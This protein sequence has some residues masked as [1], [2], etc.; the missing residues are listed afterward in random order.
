M[1][2]RCGWRV[3]A[4]AGT[5]TAEFNLKPEGS[6]TVVTWSMYGPNQFIGKVMGLFMD[7]EK[8][9]GDE[10]NKGLAKLKNVVEKK[11]PQGQAQ[12]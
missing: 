1:R 4:D 2:R 12:N 5:S 11:S 6:G 3:G 8:M 9:C 7:C 10:F